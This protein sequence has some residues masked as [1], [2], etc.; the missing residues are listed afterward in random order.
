MSTT[1]QALFIANA[2]TSVIYGRALT[3]TELTQ[4]NAVRTTAISAGRQ[5]S[6]SVTNDT[7]ESVGYWS[8]ITDA[9]S[10]ASVANAFSPAPTTACT[11]TSV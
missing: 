11:V 5:C 9:N 2:Q 8:D 1:A 6:Q 4:L 10:F 7:G 3:N